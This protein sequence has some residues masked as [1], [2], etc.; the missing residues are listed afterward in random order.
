MNIILHQEWMSMSLFRAHLCTLGVAVGL[1]ATWRTPRDAFRHGGLQYGIVLTV[2]MIAV[3][4]PLT[5]LQLSVGQLSQQDAVGIWR[6]VPF[7]RGIVCFS[8]NQHLTQVVLI[9]NYTEPVL[10]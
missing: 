5:L 1:Q 7:F 4:L 6:A 8:F 9:P 10:W 2:A 3:A